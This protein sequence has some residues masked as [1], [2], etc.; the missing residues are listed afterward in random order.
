MTRPP[1][2]DAQR[3][4]R[5]ARTA[6]AV[7]ALLSVA[8]GLALYLLADHLGLDAWTARLI[9]LAFLIAG[10]ADYAVLLAWDR[11]FGRQ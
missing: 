5:L 4:R 9:A 6:F 11:L 1:E 2:S 10:A 3:R 7:A 8:T